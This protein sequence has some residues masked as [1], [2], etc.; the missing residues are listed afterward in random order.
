VFLDHTVKAFEEDEDFEQR[1]DGA[2][3]NP[4]AIHR[5][6]LAEEALR[7]HSEMKGIVAE[8]TRMPAPVTDNMI[9]PNVMQEINR[10]YSG[11]YFN[12]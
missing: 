1:W 2:I 9:S 3:K 8:I 12:F 4:G 7:R 11:D 10:M 6:G 5:T